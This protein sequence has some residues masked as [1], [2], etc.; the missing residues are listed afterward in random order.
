VYLLHL[1]PAYKH[2]RHYVGWTSNLDSRLEAHRAG[3]GARLLEAVKEAGGSFHLART[4]P[5]SRSLER[6]I[7]DRKNAPKLCPD[8][9]PQPEPG[10]RGRSAVPSIRQ[11]AGWVM[12]AD[13]VPEPGR[14]AQSLNPWPGRAAGPDVYA[15]LLPVADQLI[16]GWRAQL[17]LP[18][19]DPTAA[20]E[21]ELELEPL[22]R[23]LDPSPT[24]V[25][26]P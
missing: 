9:S 12:A 21:P 18:G 25:P 4:W 14:D 22:V 24:S 5:G 20:A 23:P 3:R 1:D 19:P 7:K 15:D 13:V 26:R 2:A 11:E 16:S 10:A 8:C 6:A 17:G